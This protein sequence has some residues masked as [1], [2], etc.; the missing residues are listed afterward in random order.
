[1]LK[2]SDDDAISKINIGSS[3]HV[4]NKIQLAQAQNYIES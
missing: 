3:Y 1:M 4:T 2:F